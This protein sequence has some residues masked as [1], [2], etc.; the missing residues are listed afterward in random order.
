LNACEPI[1]A[2]RSARK[3]RSFS[4]NAGHAARQTII[5]NITMSQIADQKASMLMGATFLVFTLALGQ[6]SRSA[7]HA[8]LALIVLGGFAF[9]AAIFAISVV[10]PSF[11]APLAG[12][13]RDNLMFFGVIGQLEEDI[14]VD[15]MIENLSEDETLFRMMMRDAWQNSRV[16][17]NKKYR[18]LGYAYR[19]FLAGLIA[20]AV[21]F[22][23]Q[24]FGVAFIGK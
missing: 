22:V 15:R 10:M 9:V 24:F 18:L 8:P 1:S 2:E 5:N 3:A 23:V 6:A 19:T 11:H 20:S 13:G 4:S 12:E 14:Y 21:V 16:L 7:G 17:R